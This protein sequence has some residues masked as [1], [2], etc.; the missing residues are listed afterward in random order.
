MTLGD[1]SVKMF[2]NPTGN[3]DG[4]DAD[5]QDVLAYFEGQIATPDKFSGKIEQEVEKVLNHEEWRRDQEKIEEGKEIGRKL[6]QFESLF[7]LFEEGLITKE[8]LLQK[9]GLSE[10]ELEEKKKEIK[11]DLS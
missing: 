4:M 9:T 2:V 5:I 7:S 6:G 10:T 11:K 1:D 3:K 8:V